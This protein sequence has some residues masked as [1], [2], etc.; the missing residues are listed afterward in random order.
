MNN[1]LFPYK[2]GSKS[3]KVLAE[4]L[5]IKRI[6][7]QRS[8]W[9]P[10]PQRQVINWGCGVER[11]PD[12]MKNPNINWLNTP[13][14]VSTAS[15]K[16]K[17]FDAMAEHGVRT[18]PFTGQQEEAQGWLDE[19]ACIVVRHKV[20][21]NSGEGVELVDWDEVGGDEK[22]DLPNAKLYTKYIPKKQEYRIH[23][24]NGEVID[25]QRKAR[26]K[27]MDDD[28]INWQIRNYNNGFIFARNEGHAFPEDV[29][30]E[31]I[32]AVE[33]C[34]LDFGAVDVIYN[35]RKAEAYVVEVNTACGLEGETLANYVE[36]F[37]NG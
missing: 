4:A 27:D 15:H 31:A 19:G 1:Y 13:E 5:G 2:T 22:P 28:E 32:K 14:A 11:L 8:K 18:V 21:G 6:R 24:F 25:R 35:E 26:R 3:S 17:A 16:V 20:Q 9:K 36:A 29:E 12:H 34:G 7:H 33:A 37:Q 30:R 23:V 10:S